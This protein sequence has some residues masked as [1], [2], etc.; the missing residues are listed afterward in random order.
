MI[1]VH[2]SVNYLNVPEYINMCDVGIVPLPNS[3][4]WRYQC[5]LKLLEYLA[6]EKV[7][8]ATDIPANRNVLKK[9]KCGIYVSSTD[10]KQIAEA[11]VYAYNHRNELKKWGVSGREIIMERYSWLKVSG[12][13]ERYLLQIR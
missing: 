6:M 3:P 9:S 10:P 5:P 4:D 13:L 1:T 12:D 2:D 8:I 7:V 11:I